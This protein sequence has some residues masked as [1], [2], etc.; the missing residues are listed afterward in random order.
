M[1]P[2][3]RRAM[4]E[5]EI[6]KLIN[7]GINLMK[8]P[9]VKN[10]IISVTHVKL[11]KDKAY[12]DIYISTLGSEEEIDN[13]LEIL[14]KAKGFLRTYIA[15]NL[16]IFKVPEIRF[17]KDEGIQASVRIHKILEDIKNPEGEEKE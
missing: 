16:R 11:S 1:N 14:N 3:Y 12:A 8:D 9:R 10:K 13:I 4:L 6:Q 5:S 15:K 17:W 2:E 7:E